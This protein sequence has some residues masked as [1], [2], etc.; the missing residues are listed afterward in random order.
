MPELPEVETVKRGLA[1]VMEGAG[2]VR[3]EVRRPD[4]RRPFPKNMVKRLE[5]T[6]ILK[7]GRRS[8]YLLV[9]TSRDET[10]IWHLGMSGRV[11]IYAPGDDM[12]KPG[13]HD[14]VEFELTNGS[15]IV[16]TDPRRFGLMDL[17]GSENLQ[18]HPLIKVIGPEPIGNSF[19]GPVLAER[20]KGKTQG[21][22]QAIMDARVV[23]GVGN[24]YASESLFRAGLSPKRKAGTVQGG[25]AEKL[26]RAIKNVLD[27]AIHA[28][29]STL[30]DHR[31]TDG[32]LGY[33]QHNFAVYDREG[34][35]CPGCDCDISK[36]KGIQRLEQGGRSTYYCPRKQ[37]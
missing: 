25:R 15:V 26:V 33:F 21:I 36:T 10:L 35:A 12:P 14:H 6:E 5:G 24:I 8:K 4:L 37:R 9:D 3:V 16:F 11:R 19:S 29:G 17:C 2:F 34:Q 22:K 7:V 31:T 1:P 30:R 32:E 27:E 23:C 13:K 18:D 20:L 28:G